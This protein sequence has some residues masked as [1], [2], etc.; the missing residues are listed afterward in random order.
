MKDLDVILGW[1]WMTKW[2]AHISPQTRRITVSI[3]N[4]TILFEGNRQ[5]VPHLIL[6][7][8]VLRKLRQGYYGFFVA[9]MT[10][11]EVEVR[12]EDIPVVEEFPDIFPKELPGLPLA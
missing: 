12:L 11:N 10:T 8:Q 2:V 1:Y 5:K 4:Q 6:A 7:M 9:A 3:P